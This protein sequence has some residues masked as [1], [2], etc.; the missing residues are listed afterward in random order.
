MYIVN[1]KHYTQEDLNKLIDEGE[2]F[3]ESS[4]LSDSELRDIQNKP[5]GTR[6]DPT[7]L[8]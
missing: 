1:L 8:V 6:I 5:W 3:D 4:V 2:C 7:D